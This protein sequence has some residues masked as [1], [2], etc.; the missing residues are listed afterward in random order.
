MSNQGN[1]RKKMDTFLRL[2]DEIA[3]IFLDEHGNV[4]IVSGDTHLYKIESD[5]LNSY[6]SSFEL[7]LKEVYREKKYYPLG[8]LNFDYYDRSLVFNISAPFYLKDN[9]TS[10]QY[11]AEGMSE[12]WSEWTT[13]GELAFPVLQMGRFTL[14]LRA[15]N[16]LGQ[17]SFIKSYPV[18]ISPPWWLSLPF[19]IA[20]GV[21]LVL[22]ILLIIR[23]RVRKLRRD[24]EILEI[25][26]SERT[27]EIQKQ[28]DE[29]SEQKR[30]IMDSI[31]YAQ[32]IQ[33]AVLPADHLVE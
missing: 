14:H 2:F 18:T 10:Y 21:A 20:S 17:A 32:R 30:E 25:K 33:N 8:E 24:K 29:I 15:R 9:S 13:S 12:D 19:L 7:Y 5:L 11:F 4:W 16:V 22:L 28:R 31:H 26:V 1:Y 6:R 3:D 27:L 23:W